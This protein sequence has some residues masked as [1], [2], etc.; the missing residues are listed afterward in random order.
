MTHSTATP[1]SSSS[2]M[3]TSQG[4]D[5]LWVVRMMALDDL[6]R[7]AALTLLHEQMAFWMLK[8]H[9]TGITGPRVTLSTCTAL[10][11]G[12]GVIRCMMG[13]FGSPGFLVSTKCFLWL[14]CL[15]RTVYSKKVL[16]PARGSFFSRFRQCTQ[17]QGYGVNFNFTRSGKG[18]SLIKAIPGRALE[19]TCDLFS[20]HI[21]EIHQPYS[22]S[23]CVSLGDRF[24]S[25]C[26][27]F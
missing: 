14:C 10:V 18:D 19:K 21:F 1:Q 9:I 20:W 26:L 7:A 4:I 12:R 22:T 13:V 8:P 23:Q 11:L 17:Q 3:G 5:R 27:C 16:W 2:L 25:P 15:S 24:P 6:G